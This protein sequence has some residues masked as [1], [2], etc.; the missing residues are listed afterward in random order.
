[1]QLYLI[2]PSDAMESVANV[3]ENRLNEWR[4][5][6]PLGLLHLAALVPPGWD[7]TVLDENRG[8]PDYRSLPRP[9]VVGITAFTCQAPRAYEI[10]A[11]FRSRGVPAVMGGIHAT[12]RTEEALARVDA[13]VTGEAEEIW[14]QVLVDLGNGVRGR[15]YR[16]S[17]V[18][19]ARIPI[20]RHDLLPSG[21]RF[22][23]IQTTRGCPLDCHFC[24]VG[25]I[26]GRQYR[27]RPV[28]TIL[29]EM[30]LIKE[31]YLLI[32]DDNLI[33]VT[34]E[35]I[36]RAKEL[37]RAMM[38]AGIRKRW[39]AQVTINVADDEE[40]LALAA[41]SGCLGFFIGF[42]SVTPDGLREVNKTYNL[43]GNR[44]FA[45]CCRRIQSHGIAVVGSFIM[46][47]D[48]DTPGIGRTIADVASSYGVDILN[49]LLMT[50][51]PGT[52]LWNRLESERRI[53]ADRFP[54]DWAHYSFTLPVPR[55]K[56]LSWL[57]IMGEVRACRDAFFSY[58]RMLA[59]SLAMLFRPRPLLGI[60]AA[61]VTNLIYRINI[62][63]D[64]KRVRH[65][66]MGRGA[67]ADE[68][69]RVAD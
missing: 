7:V 10:A 3:R 13:V 4:I 29:E 38:A 59:R 51:L 16:G 41:R 27:A 58:R 60:F 37:F 19:M 5:W 68:L 32:V 52:R 25:A 22:G 15:V 23:S 39:V 12:V 54:D 61:V 67:S 47:L 28:A 2:N 55:F 35:Q 8:V 24:S 17:A 40:L 30:A 45:A 31:K 66:D 20:A 33:G 6:K 9:D 26:N 14:P 1:V 34:R 43:R 50:P 18:N 65:Y 63:L 44:D 42:E 11:E 36:A 69:A 64:L 46:G 21:Y 62:S 53:V 49:L 56:H 57:Q 48:V